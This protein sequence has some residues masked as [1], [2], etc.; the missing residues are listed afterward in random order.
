MQPKV[1]DPMDPL[2]E[3]VDRMSLEDKMK[4]F[5]PRSKSPNNLPEAPMRDEYDTTEEYEEA[6]GYWQGHVG[7]I[8]AMADLAARGQ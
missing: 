3:A 7:R 4:A 1:I 5:L 2:H 8:K 6:L